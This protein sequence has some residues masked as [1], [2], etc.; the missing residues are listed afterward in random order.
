MG[1][2]QQRWWLKDSVELLISLIK[3]V[4]TQPKVQATA[5]KTSQGENFVLSSS[6]QNVLTPD[7]APITI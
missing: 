7:N 1:S 4:D 6:E 5:Q 3:T 2:Q